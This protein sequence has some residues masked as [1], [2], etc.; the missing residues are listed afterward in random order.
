MVQRLRSYPPDA[1]KTTWVENSLARVA[2]DNHAC[3][4]LDALRYHGAAEL[5][6]LFCRMDHWM[7]EMLPPSIR[8]H[9]S[10]TQ[11]EGAAFC[12]FRYEKA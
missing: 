11:A 12:D 10:Q 3:F 5:T 1:W 6:T 8:F 2:V 4:Y 7:A 9:R